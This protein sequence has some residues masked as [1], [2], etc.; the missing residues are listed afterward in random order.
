V[1]MD[2][3][4]GDGP[5]YRLLES[6]SAYCVEEMRQAGELAQMR[7]RHAGCYLDLAVRAEPHLYG[8]AQRQW[9]RRLDADAANLREALDSLVRR[10]AAA[11]ALRMAGALT[12]YW[13]LRGRFTE[14]R[15]SLAATLAVA[16][17]APAAVRG[18]AVAWHAGIAALLG[19]TDA[20]PARHHAALRLY[21]DA[22]DPV[23]RAR[24]EWFVASVMVELGELAA[25]EDLVH[26]ALA[27]F[28]A[29]G[30]R[31]GE[32][33]A[34]T[35]TA[36]LA[37]VRSDL[38]AL[39]RDARQSAEVFRA[40][41][42]RWGILQATGWLIGLAEI[43]GDYEQASRLSHDGLRVAEELELWPDVARMLSWLGWIAVEL[44]DYVHARECCEQALRLAAEQ[45][46]EDV[47]ATAKIGLAFAA[48]RDGKL[49]LAEERL[50]DLVSLARRRG[51]TSGQALYLS[52]VLV[53]L[54][55]LAEQRGDPA[56][57]LGL[58]LDAFDIAQ[59]QA[60]PGD[61]A[62]ALE[63]VAA[64][65]ASARR[66][67]QAAH[68]LGAA[69]AIRGDAGLSPAPTER[70]SINRVTAAARA[71]LGDDAFA[72]ALAR[73]GE[74]TPAQAR[75]LVDDVDAQQPAV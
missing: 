19:E 22:G 41:G 8:Q 47:E 70:D 37:H 52:M 31:W 20:W 25:G 38:A 68:L 74:L 27:T 61:L 35:T 11:D 10:G 1:V 58:H 71:A 30:D 65:L 7:R 72:A 13:F 75:A 55:F 26:R 5:R 44:G 46:F 18:K 57:A 3:R 54:G 64:T 24:S 23:G 34:L 50:R 56:A 33:V 67:T 42:D 2:D 15:R 62:W 6:V 43:T 39:E 9:L 16:G 49:D 66:H 17:D 14:A 36:K 4:A 32:A 29:F 53:E 28:R 63:G 12:W 40:L 59:E 69:A 45:G 73:G 51:R 60:A 48:R 21:E